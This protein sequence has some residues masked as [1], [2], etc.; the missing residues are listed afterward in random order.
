LLLKHILCLYFLEFVCCFS[1]VAG[2]DR[3]S[4]TGTGHQNQGK[5]QSKKLAEGNEYSFILYSIQ[6][7]LNG[8]RFVTTRGSKKASEFLCLA[9]VSL[10]S[11]LQMNDLMLDVLVERHASKQVEAWKQAQNTLL[12]TYL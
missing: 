7:A 6:S 10:P 12:C 9:C 5:S 1:Y 2:H 3:T 4:I 8:S 11:I